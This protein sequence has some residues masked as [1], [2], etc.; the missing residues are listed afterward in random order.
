MA[1]VK[2]NGAYQA[3]PRK[4]PFPVLG[5]NAFLAAGAFLLAIIL[6]PFW[7]AISVAAVFAFGL[8]KPFEWL[9][10]RLNNRRRLTAALSVGLLT[11][12]LFFPAMLLG[13]RVYEMVTAPKEQSAFSAACKAGEVLRLPIAHGEGRYVVSDAE[14]QTMERE[15][16]IVF[17][18]VNAAG[19]PVPEANPN[20]ST[21]HVAGICN[22]EGNVVGL[23]PHPERAVEAALGGTDGR[24]ILASC[25]RWL[26]ERSATR[27]R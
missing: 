1:T 2:D 21:A 18:Y 22:R 24:R 6:F 8:S 17:R 13:L 12:L 4:W 3:P 27:V 15:G 23:M 7:G 25:V 11:V 10:R 20:G 19:E 26:E 16:R 14:L 9:N 5:R